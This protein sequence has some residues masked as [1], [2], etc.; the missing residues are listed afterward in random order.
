MLDDKWEQVKEKIRGD[1]EVEEELTGSIEDIPNSS[2]ET[3]IFNSPIGRI[4]ATRYKK[5]KV[6]DK[7]TQFSGRL[8]GEVNV[9]YV[10]SEDEMVDNLEILKWNEL[11]QNW[12]E[13]DLEL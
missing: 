10:Y 5:P 7:K 9:D 4:K 8:G 11:S 13:T 1:F 6:L 3:I 2:Y 12:V